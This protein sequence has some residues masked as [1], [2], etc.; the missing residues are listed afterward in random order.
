MR[1]KD[2]NILVDRANELS[3]KMALVDDPI[4]YKKLHTRL[5]CLV[6]LIRDA[7]IDLEEVSPPEEG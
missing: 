2:F 1:L 6:I 5:M 7:T 3:K 4:E